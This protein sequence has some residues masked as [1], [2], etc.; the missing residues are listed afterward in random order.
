MSRKQRFYWFV[1]KWGEPLATK[2]PTQGETNVGN[3]IVVALI[4]T[5]FAAPG[6]PR[7]DNFVVE[8]IIGQYCLSEGASGVQAHRMVHHRVYVADS[9]STSIALR[10]LYTADD[11]DSSFLW[12]K[13]EGFGAGW[14]G[15][16]FGNWQTSD[17]IQP[18]P[19]QSMGR[20]G[21]IDIKVG[22]RVEEGQTLLWHTQL[23]ATGVGPLVDGS[24]GLMLW[25]RLLM[26]EG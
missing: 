10:D 11:A 6:D 8:R 22:R 16:A 7:Q 19:T 2:T 4:D 26:R 9:D 3:D 25:V 20:Q 15:D 13:T 24:W 5:D 18:A 21:H 12:H 1:P 17:T 14:H 23:E